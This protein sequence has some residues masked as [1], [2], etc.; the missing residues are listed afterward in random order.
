LTSTEETIAEKC[1]RRLIESIRTTPPPDLVS[2][3]PVE[4]PP[5][6]GLWWTS[7][8]A[9]IRQPTKTLGHLT[10]VLLHQFIPLGLYPILPALDAVFFQQSHHALNHQ[11]NVRTGASSGDGVLAELDRFLP[12]FR[13]SAERWAGSLCRRVFLCL[14]HLWLTEVNAWPL[15][16]FCSR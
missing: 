7:H 2:F 9:G 8:I 5:P 1:R 12:T 3:R 6:T 13:R 14:C 15:D 10:A 4:P 16:C 11:G